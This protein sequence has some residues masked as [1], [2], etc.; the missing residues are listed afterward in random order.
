MAALIALGRRAL[1]FVALVALICGVNYASL[2]PW[3]DRLFGTWRDPDDVVCG[4]ALDSAAVEASVAAT[5]C[6][7]VA[8]ASQ[9]R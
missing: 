6:S 2:F 5:V 8:I 9:R 4:R 7:L 1:A 3:I